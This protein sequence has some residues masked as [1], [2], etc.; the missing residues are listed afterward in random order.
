MPTV[1]DLLAKA[2]NA[3]SE[4]TEVGPQ[5]GQDK[6]SSNADGSQQ[7]SS[8]DSNKPVSPS[9]TDTESSLANN[10][11]NSSGAKRRNNYD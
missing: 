2:A 1:A 6:S 11:Q 4:Q 10:S 9:V 5:A 7:A 3:P 8:P